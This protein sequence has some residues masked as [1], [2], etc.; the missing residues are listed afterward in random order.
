MNR[1][2][3]RKEEKAFETRVPVVPDHV[4]LLQSKYDI[5][6]VLEPSDQRAFSEDEYDIDVQSLRGSGVSIVMGIKE[7]PLD[8]FEKDVVYIFFSHT[9]KGQPKNM[10]ML[11]KIM[12][13]GATLIDYEKV[14][15]EKG[16][17]LIFFGNWAGMAGI[18]NTFRILGKRL[19]IMGIRPN[20]FSKMKPTLEIRELNELKEEFRLLGNRIKE[21]GLPDKLMPF[22]IGF[23][24]YGNVSRGAQEIFDILP[25]KTI[26][27]EEL[28]HLTPEPNLI[29]KCIFKE[30]HM[31]EPKDPSTKFDLQD[32]YK[33]GKTKYIGVFHKHVPYLTV[34]MNCI[35]WSD[36]YPRL[37][38]L[39]FIRNHWHNDNR[40]L[41][42]I[43]D[44]S[45]DI[46]GAIEFT[47]QCTNPDK[48][49]F[50]YII[51]EDRA[52]LGIEGEGPVIMAVD[53]LPCELPRES[54]T[55]FSE[56]LLDF[57]PALASTD[58]TVP[59]SKLDLPRELKDAVIVY[60]GQ[61]TREFQY[62]EQ[63]LS[64]EDN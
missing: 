44:I 54:S 51:D 64:K 40:K 28:P 32:Y 16:R 41:Q 49:A 37:L 60:R 23:A 52:E 42:I 2:G 22:V 48:P 1:I 56:T 34:L 38:T 8:I 39:D 61:L 50:T 43:G 9:V 17:R 47:V 11:K 35:Y 27:P 24:G 55:S 53:N 6:F 31:V 59:Y 36:K 15:N 57:I 30:E 5:D 20:P 12:D 14:V 33:Y 26:N 19:E 13:V 63:Y 3:L 4:K 7:M 58:F 62:L 29:Y 10:P 46:R 21:Q 45:C 18:S 25:H